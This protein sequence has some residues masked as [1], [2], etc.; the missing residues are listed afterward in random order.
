MSNSID[1]LIGESARIT[2]ESAEKST[3]KELIDALRTIAGHLARIDGA[4]RPWLTP[5]LNEAANRL[6]MRVNSEISAPAATGKK[7]VV[8]KDRE[9]WDFIQRH[10]RGV[11][12]EPHDLALLDTND[13]RRLVRMAVNDWCARNPP[14]SLVTNDQSPIPKPE[15]AP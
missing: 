14:V 4:A 8:I 10:M 15:P 9:E 3:D 5:W 2:R 12:H 1:R 6:Q 11:A 13:Y 7:V